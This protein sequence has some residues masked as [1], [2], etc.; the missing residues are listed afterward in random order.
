M[1]VVM[2]R[3]PGRLYMAGPPVSLQKAVIKIAATVARLTGRSLKPGA[4]E[5]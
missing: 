2:N 1:A 4:E 3:F 5:A